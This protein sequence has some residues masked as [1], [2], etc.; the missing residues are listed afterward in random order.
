[1][2]FGYTNTIDPTV[3]LVDQ[4]VY[5]GMIGSL[6]YLT[7]STHEIVFAMGLCAR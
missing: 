2:V 3:E 5:E 4:K 1:M 6:L 7:A